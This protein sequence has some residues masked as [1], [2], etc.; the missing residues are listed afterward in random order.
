MTSSVIDQK[1]NNA[2]YLLSALWGDD[3]HVHQLSYKNAKGFFT[4]VIVSSIS[5]ALAKSEK[6]NAKGF[7]VYFACA[8]YQ[9]NESRL[10]SNT[11]GAWGYWFDIDCGEGKAK[12]GLGYVDKK[13]AV[14]AL[15][16]FIAQCGFPPPSFLVDSGN[17]L[18]VYFCSDRFIPTADWQTG[19]K[20][21]KA[22]TKHYDFLADDTRTAD[23]ASIL[24]VPDSLNYKDPAN[25]KPVRLLVSKPEYISNILGAIN[26][27]YEAISSLNNSES[28]NSVLPTYKL[29]VERLGTDRSVT[30]EPYPFTP[31]HAIQFSEA[32]LVAYPNIQTF[33]EFTAWGLSCASLP[34]TQKWP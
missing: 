15:R 26:D 29:S 27:T 7:D 21:L 9:T 28:I 6:L 25:P 16:K 13:V 34:V 18:H 8:E 2:E 30:V 20:K 33:D 19:A 5:E 4:P 14:A 3:N 17:G 32:G 12:Q 10:A 1:I 23:I 11:I 24:R 22:L 31:E